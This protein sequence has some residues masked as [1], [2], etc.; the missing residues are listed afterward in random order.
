MLCTRDTGHTLL[1]LT[2]VSQQKIPYPWTN[3]CGGASSNRMSIFGS[4]FPYHQKLDNQRSVRFPVFVLDRCVFLLGAPWP[5][6]P[7]LDAAGF[8]FA[9]KFNN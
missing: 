4:P 8:F 6:L 9:D 5:P 1:E 3:H 2:Q 7:P